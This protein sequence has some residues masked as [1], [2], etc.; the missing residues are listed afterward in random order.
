MEILEII[1]KKQNTLIIVVFAMAFSV[2]LFLAIKTILS[3]T[4]ESSFTPT[5]PVA[6]KIDFELLNSQILKGLELFEG[7]SVPEDK[8]R[9]NPF[10]PYSPDSQVEHEV[11]DET[12]DEINIEID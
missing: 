6:I 5:P 7:A 3:K 11:E 1:K 4:T 2:F 8:G 12:E 9:E 10:I